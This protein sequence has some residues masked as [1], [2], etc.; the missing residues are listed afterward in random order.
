MGDGKTVKNTEKELKIITIEILLPIKNM[1]GI[2]K[3]V[4]V[5]DKEKYTD[6]KTMNYFMREHSKTEES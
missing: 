6:Y 2:S 5:Q 1:L 3:T 4:T